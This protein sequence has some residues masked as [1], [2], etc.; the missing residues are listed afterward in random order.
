MEESRLLLDLA[1]AFGVALGGGIIAR[2][3]KQPAILGYLIAGIVIGPYA[4]G[5]VHSTA[6]I[7]ILATVGVVLLL[8][9]LGIEFSFQ[10][11][12]WVRNVA[13]FGGIAQII[14]TT[15]L[16]MLVAM[17]LLGQSLREAIVFG[18]L[19]SLSSTMV[20]I[21]MLVDRGET[22]SVH[23]RVMIGIL[24][25]Q[26]VAAAFAMFILPVL[27]V[28]NGELL[29]VLGIAFLKAGAFIALVVVAG[30]WLIP[31]LLRRVALRQ[32]RELCIIAVTALCL[33]GAFAAYYFGLSAALGAFAI[34]LMVSESDFAHQALGNIAPLRDLFSA[35]FFVSV[36]M[37]IDLPFL[38]ANITSLLM[39][40]VAIILIKFAVCSGIVHAFGYREKTVPLV[41]AGMIQV[42]E[43]SFVLAELCLIA[44]VITGY[45]YSMI[46]GSALVTI[47]LTP[48]IFALTSK[49]CVKRREI[50]RISGGAK[51]QL[52]METP[53]LTGHVVICGHGRVGSHAARVLNQLAVP[54]IVI[55][56]DPRT[57]S[58][59][60]QR[61]IPCVYGDGGNEKVL[62]EAGVK[63]A[64]VLVLASAD[65]VSIRLAVDHARRINQ[66]LDI[67]A[68][69]HNDSELE[70]L[71]NRAVSEVVR[72]ETEAGIEIVR[73]ILCHLDMPVD[74]VEEVITSQRGICSR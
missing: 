4:L 65:S 60:R 44:G 48:F 22:N 30:I 54:Y 13:V 11:L 40:V 70:F 72:P 51:E 33:G 71:Q 20:V 53:K 6:N 68:R 8:F 15:A 47:V 18:L 62:Y 73:H 28:G 23:G 21:G 38:A 55:D 9:T 69:A 50:S 43:F 64:A 66:K 3:L 63:D 19:I 29:P 52:A 74:K 10:E 24:L 46:L 5:L 41:G 35:L 31:R 1:I 7:Q 67:I 17:F 16:G 57:I 25:L 59:L 32:S 42:G 2:L 36:G 27:G 14:A 45:I 58:E 34:G 37:L 39:L 49:L 56:L 12:R 26:D 61:G